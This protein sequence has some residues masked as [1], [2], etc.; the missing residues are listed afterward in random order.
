MD[1]K[2][3][4][5][6]VI[7]VLLEIGVDKYQQWKLMIKANA[8]ESRLEPVIRLWDKIFDEVDSKRPFRRRENSG[9]CL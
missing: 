8:A 2:N 5:E 3:L 6:D 1:L 4:V 9:K 7:C